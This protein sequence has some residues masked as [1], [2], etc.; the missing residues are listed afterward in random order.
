MSGPRIYVSTG[1]ASGDLHSAPV[2]RSLQRRFPDAT[3]EATGGVHL[4]AAGATIRHRI[5]H[6]GAMGAAEILSSIP[7][8]VRLFADLRSRLR[9]GMYDLVIAVDYPG[10]NVRLGAAAA[11][12]GVPVLY[13]IAPQ[14]WAW[15]EGRAA[16]LRQSA[17]QLAVILPFE[18][19]FF[20]GLGI[21]AAFVGHPLLERPP[22][23]SR[24]EARRRLG[25]SPSEPTLGIFPGS[26]PQETARLWP[27]FREAARLARSAIPELRLVVAGISGFTYPDSSDFVVHHDQPDDVLMAAD[28]GLCK[29]GTT[30]LEAALAD[31]PM[32]VAYR[33]H[34]W[35]FALARRVVR[36][37]HIALVNLVAGRA[38]A[39][40]LLQQAA[41]A[42]QLAVALLPLLDPGGQPA[43]DQRSAFAEVRERL[44]TPGAGERVA[45]MA[46]QLVA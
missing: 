4:A 8:H 24:L 7:R 26:R 35:S 1:E 38:I 45:E 20:R 14:L 46:A 43:T 25:F 22:R 44:G 6:L 37:P 5:E 21:P 3:I 28:A 39:P 15:G 19:G 9:A 32:V 13:Y 34:P 41:T 10:F 18:E 33:M 36:V 40:E 42:R 12:A 2:V 27:A 29:S 30:T 23:P 16:A 31:L 11:R 17:R